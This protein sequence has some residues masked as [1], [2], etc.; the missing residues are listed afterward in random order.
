MCTSVLFR[1]VFPV[2]GGVIVADVVR[3]CCIPHYILC[4]FYLGKGEVRGSKPRDSTTYPLD[5]KEHLETGRYKKVVT[6]STSVLEKI[7]L[8]KILPKTEVRE[9]CLN[10]TGF[11]TKGYGRIKFKGKLYLVTRLVCEYHH[12]MYAPADRHT[13]RVVVMHTCDNPSCV[14]PAHLMVGTDVDN[15][16]DCAAKGRHGARKRKKP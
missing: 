6:F 9:N 5:F 11:K 13:P 7:I 14:N 1:P 2:L 10:Y 12:G 15:M 4:D 16:R 3:F 8:A